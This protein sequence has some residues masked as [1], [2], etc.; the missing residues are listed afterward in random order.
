VSK[1]TFLG[2]R[3]KSLRVEIGAATEGFVAVTAFANARSPSPFERNH[4]RV[5]LVISM[6]DVAFAMNLLF[7]AT[8]AA[9][10][11]FAPG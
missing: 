3:R 11:D 7:V 6:R 8:K 2:F 4:A 5:F 9:N 10:H 1:Y